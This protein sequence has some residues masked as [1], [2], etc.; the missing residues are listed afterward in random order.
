MRRDPIR[1]KSTTCCAGAD[2]LRHAMV[3]A[4]KPMKRRTR[5]YAPPQTP[6]SPLAGAPEMT[7]E[8]AA[9]SGALNGEYVVEIARWYLPEAMLRHE[10]GAKPE[11]VR[12]L[13]ARGDS[14]ESVAHD[15]NRLLVDTSRRT[16]GTGEM[17]V[18]W[19]GGG[20]VVKCVEI[21]PRTDP[22]RLG[23]VSV[24]PACESYT[25]LAD[26]AHMVGTVI[27]VVRRV[28]V[29]RSSCNLHWSRGPTCAGPPMVV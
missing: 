25:C 3:L 8:A 2:E 16:L 21:V 13:R 1:Q 17:A 24:N 6:G 19:D 15:G 11:N 12:V 27:W 5:C 14:M 7:V 10:G 26:E 29:A 4:R 9:G 18:L 22:V 28:R 20:L 23:L